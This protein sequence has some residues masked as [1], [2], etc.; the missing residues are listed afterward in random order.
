MAVDSTRWHDGAVAQSSVFGSTLLVQG[1]EPLLAERAVAA[2]VA[3]ARREHPDAE[4]TE[5]NAAELADGRFADLI[6]GSLFA[7]WVIVVVNDLASLPEQALPLVRQSALEPY[8]ELCLVLVH[9][10]GL[11]G[12]ALIDALKKAKVTRIAADPVKAWELPKFVAAEA[13]SL[14]MGMDVQAAQDLIDAVGTDLRSLA[15]ALRQLASDY[16]GEQLS[17]TMV[18]R[19]FDGR[20]E[21]TSFAVADDALAGRPGPALEKLRW[22]LS[23]GVAPVL[24]TSALAGSL[25]GLGKYLELRSARMPDNDLARQVGVPPWKLKDLSRLS[26]DWSSQAVSIAIRAVA[27]ADEQ[28]KGAA[29]DPGFALEQLL[30]TVDQARQAGRAR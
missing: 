26:R 6:G 4:L 3:Q 8:P 14:R 15:G 21:V 11:K 18:R 20:A 28:V 27:R 13:K 17:A 25:R 12:K 9:G 10:G 23:T 5:V 1:A 22:A 2:R 19:Y 29:A 24:V 30:R 7:S 16:Q